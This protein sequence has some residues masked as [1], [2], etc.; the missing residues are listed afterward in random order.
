MMVV[1]VLIV[2]VL[3]NLG[4]MF[5]AFCYRR[6]AR[7]RERLALAVSMWPRGEVGAG[8]LVIALGYGLGGP[9]LAVALLSLA[10]NL[11]LTGVFILI[12]KALLTSPVPARAVGATP[13]GLPEEEAV[14]PGTTTHRGS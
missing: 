12:V 10:L 14:S 4:K 9:L 5:P 11:L 7:L 13:D 6:K 8:I 2:T 1:H 3:S